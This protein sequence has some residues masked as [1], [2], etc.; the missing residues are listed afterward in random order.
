VRLGISI[1]IREY[2]HDK[3]EEK[4][5]KKGQKKRRDR[6][7]SGAARLPNLQDSP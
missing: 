3:E 4:N 5:S 6:I 7:P 1:L 2:V